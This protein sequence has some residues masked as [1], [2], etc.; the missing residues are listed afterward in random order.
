M[1]PELPTADHSTPSNG[2]EREFSNESDL[3]QLLREQLAEA[4][5]SKREALEERQR[6]RQD[7]STIV[8][9]A[10]LKG[11]KLGEEQEDLFSLLA[12]QASREVTYPRRD[13]DGDI[14]NRSLEAQLTRHTGR[15]KLML[16]KDFV[17]KQVQ[18]HANMAPVKSSKFLPIKAQL[19]PLPEDKEG[20]ASFNSNHGNENLLP[21]SPPAGDGKNHLKIMSSMGTKDKGSTTRE[22]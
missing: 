17:D 20:A 2:G 21:H 5:A 6:T 10:R 14:I 7:L 16:G 12:P 19:F 3:M 8:Q 22:F 11:L 9:R 4:L 13:D 15:A 18:L 1:D